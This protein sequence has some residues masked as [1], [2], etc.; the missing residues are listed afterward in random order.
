MGSTFAP[1]DYFAAAEQIIPL[2]SCA[3]AVKI[4]NALQFR[5]RDAFVRAEIAERAALRVYQL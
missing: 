2:A 5:P 4:V 3:H 1:G